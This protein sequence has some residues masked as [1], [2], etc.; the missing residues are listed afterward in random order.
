MRYR[1][2]HVF[3]EWRWSYRFSTRHD[4]Q[5]EMMKRRAYGYVVGWV[6]R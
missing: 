3:G 4:A 1:Y 6:G 5:I 2:R